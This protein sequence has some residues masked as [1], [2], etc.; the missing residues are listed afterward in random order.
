[1]IMLWGLELQSQVITFEDIVLSSFCHIKTL[2]IFQQE[3]GFMRH[4]ESGSGL[5]SFPG[6][7]QLNLQGLIIKSGRAWERG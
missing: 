2:K 4:Y 1:M 7:S 6:H 3:F 5:V